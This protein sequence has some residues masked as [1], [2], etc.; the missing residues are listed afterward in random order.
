LSSGSRALLAKGFLAVEIGRW[1]SVL[2]LSWRH[3]RT[4]LLSGIC[5]SSIISPDVLAHLIVAAAFLVLLLLDI[6][7][8]IYIFDKDNFVGT[9]VLLLVLLRLILKKQSTPTTF[10][11]KSCLAAAPG[12]WRLNA[13]ICGR[14]SK[15][16]RSFRLAAW[17]TISW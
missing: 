5:G 2:W 7:Y 17:Q 14:H 9:F 11:V 8:V 4:V 13:C 16:I 10:C 12:R 15:R 1:T 3:L 6:I